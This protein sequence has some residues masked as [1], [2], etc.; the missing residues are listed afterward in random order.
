M[1]K[2]NELTIRVRQIGSVIRREK[3][4]ALYLKS[5][6]LSGI[7]TERELL[8]SH[9]VLELIKKVRHMVRIVQ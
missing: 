9:A 2:K 1:T 8:V 7:G 6:G 4:Q 5:L 3:R